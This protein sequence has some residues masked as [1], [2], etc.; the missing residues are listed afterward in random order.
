MKR[1]RP[2]VASWGNVRGDALDEESVSSCALRV[3]TRL[4]PTELISG[5]SKVV[6]RSLDCTKSAPPIDLSRGM[7]TE[8][9][10]ALELS[11]TVPLTARS[12]GRSSSG[13]EKAGATVRLPTIVTHCRASA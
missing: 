9:S 8:V 1:S 6:S 3:T 13:P 5:K 11:R 7:L 2:T 12:R 4:G 10:C